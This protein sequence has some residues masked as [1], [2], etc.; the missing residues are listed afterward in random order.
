MAKTN[1]GLVEYA[2]AQLGLP[3]WYGTY[4]Q[5]SSEELYKRKKA[6]YP[7]NYTA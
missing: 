4:G 2:K 6:Q 1:I 7:R 3:Y 5:I